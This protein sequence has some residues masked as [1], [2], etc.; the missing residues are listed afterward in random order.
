MPQL[1]SCFQMP[2]SLFLGKKK[3]NSYRSLHF[4]DTQKKIC[5][6]L[7]VENKLKC[8]KSF[9][10]TH[11]KK[12]LFAWFFK[13]SSVSSSFSREPL[14]VTG[15]WKH[16]I[17][18]IMKRKDTSLFGRT[19]FSTS[20]QEA[21]SGEEAIKRA[22]YLGPSTSPSTVWLIYSYNQNS[23][24]EFNQSPLCHFGLI[25]MWFFSFTWKAFFRLQ[26][27]PISRIPTQPIRVEG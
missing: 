20:T 22:L 1:N 25:A 4:R 7:L 9:I 24:C 8:S 23:N 14:P 2:A 10:Y 16:M 15:F 11:N 26:T 19:K 5:T 21:S 27:L 12:F 3:P 13:D 18:S 6:G 17:T